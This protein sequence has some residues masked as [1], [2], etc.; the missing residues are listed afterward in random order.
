[1]GYDCYIRS[2]SD[3]EPEWPDPFTPEAYEKCR[4]VRDEWEER[5]HGYFRRSMSGGSRLADA[6]VEMGMGFDAEVF[7]PVPPWP[8]REEYVVEEYDAETDR[9]LDWHGPEIPGIHYH[10][11]C[12]SNDGWHVTREECRSALALY[13]FAIRDGKAH[14]DAFHDDFIPFLRAAAEHDGFEVH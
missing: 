9:V 14:P 13:E 1:M 5:T 4:V 6:L 11:V 3:P 12:T 7:V 2:T 10:K 8:S